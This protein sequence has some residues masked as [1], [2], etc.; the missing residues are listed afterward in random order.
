MQTRGDFPSKRREEIAMLQPSIDITVSWGFG[1]P[2]SITSGSVNLPLFDPLRLWLAKSILRIRE[3]TG[4]LVLSDDARR[5]FIM[6][7]W[8]LRR[9]QRRNIEYLN[10]APETS[11]GR[12]HEPD[13]VTDESWRLKLEV[14]LAGTEAENDD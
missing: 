10:A 2:D 9:N 1:W 4:L 7:F 12:N 6:N 13:D 3:G 11:N 14:G 8:K 5:S